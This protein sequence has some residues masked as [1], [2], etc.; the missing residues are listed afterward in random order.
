MLLV[1][2]RH[3]TA[4]ADAGVNVTLKE[5]ILAACSTLDERFQEEP[6]TE[7]AIRL[8]AAICLESV[9]EM[10]ASWVKSRGAKTAVKVRFGVAVEL[11]EMGVGVPSFEGTKVAQATTLSPN[12]IIQMIR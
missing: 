7:G 2:A 10:E 6:E 4:E 11:S 9:G 12:T 1:D 8:A 3:G 5:A